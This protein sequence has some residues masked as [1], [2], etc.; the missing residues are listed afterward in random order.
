[1]S[2][3]PSSTPLTEEQI[4]ICRLMGHVDALSRLVFSV[5]VSSA[6]AEL[7]AILVT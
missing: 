7:A 5:F 4:A 2:D 1:M 6:G 3:T